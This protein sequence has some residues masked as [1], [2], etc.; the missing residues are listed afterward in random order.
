[1]RRIL[2]VLV[3][4]ASLLTGLL[5]AQPK[6]ALAAVDPACDGSA[7]FL[8]FPTWYKYLNVVPDEPGAVDSSC[9]IVGPPGTSVGNSEVDWQKASG[10]V[11]LAV[12][13]ILLRI[14]ALAAVGY[15]M[16][17]GFRYITSQGDPEGA[18]TA[19]Q[20]IINGLIGLV[21]SLVATGA[22]AFIANQLT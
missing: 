19:R 16:Y 5:I 2:I 3:L 10:Y 14:A 13:E 6:T 9:S 17:G 15:V 4:S 18:K 1:M 12:V 11:A 22:V 21:I 7:G 8:S 20:T